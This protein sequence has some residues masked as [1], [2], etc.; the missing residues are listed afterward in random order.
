[1]LSDVRG[2]SYEEKLEDAGLTTLRERRG[3]GDM[4]EVFKTMKGFNKVDKKKWF[5]LADDNQMRPCT[6]SNTE[7][8]ND[9][10]GEKKRIDIIEK[11][12]TRLEIRNNFFTVR[13]AR[14]W[15]EIPVNKL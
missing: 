7:I 12:R 6:R 11:E 14:Q 15:N 1:M 2:D 5:L 8:S 4:I 3:R 9:G 10:H 13:V